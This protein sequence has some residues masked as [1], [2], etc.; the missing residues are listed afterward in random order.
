VLTVENKN[1]L[2]LPAFTCLQIQEYSTK[3]KTGLRGSQQR[4]N[5]IPCKNILQ[6]IIQIEFKKNPVFRGQRKGGSSK[7]GK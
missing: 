4:I 5:I 7:M 2:K 3:N 6:K 1:T